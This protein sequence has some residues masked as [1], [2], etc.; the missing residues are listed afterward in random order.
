LAVSP[1]FDRSLCLFLFAPLSLLPL[2]CP[3]PLTLAFSERRWRKLQVGSA[4]KAQSLGITPEEAVERL[5]HEAR[6]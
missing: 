3:N 5:V 6:R 4:K 2:G 1:P